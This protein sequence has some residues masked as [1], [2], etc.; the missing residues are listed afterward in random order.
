M[1]TG[2]FPDPHKSTDGGGSG[3]REPAPES[4]LTA[5]GRGPSFKLENDQRF[6]AVYAQLMRLARR[7]LGPGDTLNTT[8]V[9]HELYL[10]LANDSAASI[11]NERQFLGYAA[12]AMRNLLI[13]RARSRLSEKSGGGQIALS[14]D[15]AR[16]VAVSVDAREALALDDALRQLERED[17]RAAEVLEL[18]YFAGQTTERIAELLGVTR[19]T[20]ERDLQ[21]ARAYLKASCA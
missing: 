16:A 15:D 17:A 4:A 12:R 5:E 1:K 19:R 11:G 6:A 20:V 21:F 8:G 13:D 3:R 18:N 14:L 7:Q 10:R 2:A 9:V